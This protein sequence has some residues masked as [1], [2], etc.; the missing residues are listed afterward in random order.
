MLKY[1]WIRIK[2]DH[3]QLYLILY[4]RLDVISNLSHVRTVPTYQTGKAKNGGSNIYFTLFSIPCDFLLIIFLSKLRRS[5]HLLFLTYFYTFFRFSIQLF[6]FQNLL[7]II[8]FYII[9]IK[10]LHYF[11]S[12]YL[13]Y[14][15][16]INWS[17]PYLHFSLI[18]I[19]LHV[20]TLF[21]E[22]FDL[23]D[24]LIW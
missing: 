19:H 1:S 18:Y 24:P 10:Y 6:T 3:S 11:S 17:H 23:Y 12:L 15:L 8:K 20:S 4:H 16:N 9:K 14:T 5:C 13:I 7:N 2:Q 22:C 21:I